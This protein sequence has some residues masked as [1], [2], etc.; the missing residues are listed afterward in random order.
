MPGRLLGHKSLF[1]STQIMTT[2]TDPPT[3]SVV[4]SETPAK[5]SQLHTQTMGILTR[6]KPRSNPSL[7]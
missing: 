5:T 1:D 3:V 4:N 2:E 6:L 7:D